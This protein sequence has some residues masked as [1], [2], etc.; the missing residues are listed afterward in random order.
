M[1]WLYYTTVYTNMLLY[2]N[3]LYGN[4]MNS[5]QTLFNTKTLTSFHSNLASIIYKSHNE[6]IPRTM[7]V[8]GGELQPVYISR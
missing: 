8:V 1:Y 2:C 5:Y 4:A 3:C 6:N 7:V